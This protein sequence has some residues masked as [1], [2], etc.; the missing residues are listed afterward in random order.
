MKNIYTLSL[1]PILFLSVSFL[2]NSFAQPSTTRYWVGPASSNFNGVNWSTTSGGGS[3]TASN[4]NINTQYVFDGAG[5]ANQTYTVTLDVTTLGFFTVKN[6]TTV[7]L[8]ST[9]TSGTTNYDFCGYS[10]E[11]GSKLVVENASASGTL[12]LS[13]IS[14]SY[15]STVNGEL[16]ARAT[17]STTQL[18]FSN[19]AL[20][21]T[22]DIFGTL[23]TTGT[24]SSASISASATKLNFKANS[25]LIINTDNGTSFTANCD[26][27]MTVTI[28]GAGAAGSSNS[29]SSYLASF[30][31]WGNVIYNCPNQSV[32]RPLFGG[33]SWTIK[34]NLTIVNTGTAKLNFLGTGTS[35]A[36]L[37]QGDLTVQSGS[38]ADLGFY[39]ATNP[40]TAT[41]VTVNGNLTLQTGTTF[42][43]SSAADGTN[44]FIVLKGNFINS[45]ILTESG[46]SAGSQIELSGT[47]TQGISN[48]GTISNDVSFK[49]NNGAGFN[50][51]TDLFL[52]ASS[53]A[54]LNMYKGVV[55]SISNSWIVLQNPAVSSLVGGADTCYL[56]GGSFRRF[57]NSTGNYLFPVGNSRYAPLYTI[58]SGSGSN[59]MMVSYSNSGYGIYTVDAPLNHA[60]KKEYWKISR[61]T[62]TDAMEVGLQVNDLNFSGV[63]VNRNILSAAG[64]AGGNWTEFSYGQIT[65]I[66][67]GSS[68]WLKASG[69]NLGVVLYLTLA[70]RLAIGAGG[71][72]LGD[73]T[74]IDDL[75]SQKDFAI[76]LLYPNPSSG[77]IQY[78]VTSRYNSKAFVSLMDLHGKMIESYSV[79]LLPGANQLQMNAGRLS[80]GTYIIRVSGNKGQTAT[81]TF[82]RL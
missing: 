52:P 44:A 68:F 38:G 60:S 79:N 62:G 5:T 2:N 47:S 22:C 36:N 43:L 71:N 19:F 61:F 67:P 23:R 1:L 10:I 34:G 66:V 70:D 28:M 53:N 58:P 56:N 26:P 12:K 55:N 80:K 42:D 69:V 57:T 54:V 14:T 27:T 24:A 40:G 16:E 45:G 20:G 17:S 15:Q 81:E 21:T 32:N 29:T 33:G 8:K 74:G 18:D 30:S 77:A 9:T 7:I 65:D 46:T 63:N 13:T 6:N 48:F 49:L 73:I 76:D 82:I 78:R 25:N 39:G 59:D 37:I 64:T 51:N 4:G 11:A 41:T 31:S 35:S 50:L 75:T 72:G 3:P